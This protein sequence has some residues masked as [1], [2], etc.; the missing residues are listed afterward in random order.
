MKV[1]DRRFHLDGEGLDSPGRKRDTAVT[2]GSKVGIVGH[3]DSSACFLVQVNNRVNGN[4]S[5]ASRPDGARQDTFRASLASPLQCGCR[6]VPENVCQATPG[7]VLRDP[8]SPPQPPP[9][10]ETMRH[11]TWRDR[12]Y[13]AKKI[14]AETSPRQ[15][16][17]TE[18]ES[19][20]DA[21]DPAPRMWIHGGQ[22]G[23]AFEAGRLPARTTSLA[24][25]AR[26]RASPPSRLVAWLRRS[27]GSAAALRGGGSAGEGG[28]GQLAQ[29]RPLP[30]VGIEVVGGEPLLVGGLQGRPLLVDHRV[31]GGVPGAASHD[32]RPPEM[33]SS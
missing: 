16:P 8:A 15:A 23:N 32:D 11:F 10:V 17:D 26:L 30:A 12:P 1:I 21:V 20:V 9:V 22:S 25:R 24:R 29:A 19:M 6:Q 14:G 4:R 31:P 18:F 28:R 2:R 13:R 3:L 5:Q 33:P 27:V 7:P